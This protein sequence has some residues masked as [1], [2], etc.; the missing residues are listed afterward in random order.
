[1]HV[2]RLSPLLLGCLVLVLAVPLA[3]SSRTASGG[4]GTTGGTTAPGPT[5]TGS[6]L[7]GGAAEVAIRPAVKPRSTT[8]DVGM[9]TPDG[10]IRTYH[11][12]VPASLHLAPPTAATSTSTVAPATRVPLLIALH[13]GLGSGTQFE[14][15]TGFD[16]LAEA[17]GFIVA[18][19][20]GWGTGPR[21]GIARTWNGGSC[22]GPA[23][24]QHVDDV[25]FI[26]L[27]IRQ[28][29]SRY[30]VDPR[31]VFVAGHSN[32]GIMAYRL[33][34]QLSGTVAA[35]GVQSTSLELRPCQP[36]E[37]VS[38]L[39]IH[40]TADKNIPIDGGVGDE[41]VAQLTFNPPIDGVRTLAAANGCQAVPSTSTDPANADL[42]IE[43]WA[44]CHPGIDVELVKVT[45]A[46]H[47]W[48]GHPAATR[49]AHPYPKLDSS[50]VIWSFLAAHPKPLP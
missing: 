25:T 10:R 14:K 7:P 35:I 37:P 27:V 13:G 15:Q 19:P 42:T 26:K 36:T 29:E 44:S 32:G 2:S 20:Y 46:A 50:S 40:G 4:A 39:H 33:A 28:I 17:N 47:A 41:G 8:I 11:L 9:T 1:M 16:G 43:R 49:R 45:G 21:H 30:P 12:Y 22:C 23:M 3:C 31:R 24:K 18:Y 34:C 38:L 5:G 48:M 6:T